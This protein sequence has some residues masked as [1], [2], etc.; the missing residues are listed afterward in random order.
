V[1]HSAAEPFPRATLNV[2][3]EAAIPLLDGEAGDYDRLLKLTAGTRVVLLG[4]SSF[5]TH[6]LFHA[7]AEL[8]KRLIQDVGFA[9]LALDAAPVEVEPIDAYV[10]GRSK[11]SLA[12]DALGRVSLFPTWM[13]RNA[14]MLD[15]VGWLRSYNDQFDADPHKV[16]VHTIN[17][18]RPQRSVVWAHSRFVG[19]ARATDADE[20]NLGQLAREGYGRLAVLVGFTTYSGTI[21]AA[22]DR[23]GRPQRQALHAAPA[24]S[25]EALC[26]ATE[27]PRFLL[28]L[29]DAP[30]RLTTALREPRPER[31]VDAVYGPDGEASVMYLHARLADQ[32]DALIHFDTTRSL[33]PLDSRGPR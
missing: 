21:V 19:D 32:F 3:R 12:D 31:M 6:E 17:L 5:G 4:V 23:D 14:E 26:H 15:F 27:I 33:E 22:L 1:T 28:R 18:G 29:R 20:P 7:R 16:G 11:T 30:E 8:T 25:Y 2:L 9:S 13:W 10:K 24:E